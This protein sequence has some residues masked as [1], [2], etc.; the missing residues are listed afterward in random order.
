MDKLKN[1]FNFEKMITDTGT[2]IMKNSMEIGKTLL[3]DNNKAAIDV[4]KK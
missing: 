3:L 1:N 2:E 4:Q